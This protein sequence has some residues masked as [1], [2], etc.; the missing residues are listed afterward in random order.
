[1]EKKNTILLTVIAVATL[2]VAVV[3]A[4]FA[5]FTATTGLGGE[6]TGATEVKS[7]QVADAAELNTTTT[8][9]T[10]AYYPGTINYASATVTAKKSTATSTAVLAVD[11]NITASVTVDDALKDNVKWTLYKTTDPVN[12]VIV[13]DS[14]GNP[15]HKNGSETRYYQ[16]CQKAAALT[17]SVKI[18][19]SADN[20][21]KNITD[22]GTL[23]T[24]AT[25]DAGET[26][27]YY[28]VVE[29]ENVETGDNANQNAQQGK[30]ITFQLN[31]ATA[32]TTKVSNE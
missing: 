14:C 12:P 8:K 22:S 9:S 25:T 29:Y 31:A 18:A 19:S 23:K 11:Y 2:L 16:T 15:E 24:L 4:T 7:A 32:T 20:D 17:D 5:Y 30:S 13:A 3:G 1:M 10:D 27:Y 21:G 26:V 6:G 28:L